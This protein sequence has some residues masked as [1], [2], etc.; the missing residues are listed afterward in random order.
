MTLSTA[1]F[2]ASATATATKS[3]AA[4][5]NAYRLYSP[6]AID[7]YYVAAPIIRDGYNAAQLWI[8]EQA[9]VVEQAIKRAALKSLIAI[10][11]L[12][13]IAF[14]WLQTQIEQ[15]PLYA[16]K[17]QLTGIKAKLFIVRQGIKISSFVSYNGLDSKAQ[18]LAASAKSA[19]IRKG[20]IAR[21]ALDKVFCLG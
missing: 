10:L 2:R 21:T 8:K 1:T 15:A 5:A 4:T 16:L 9:P 6:V 17:L 20:A 3:I 12:A 7:A 11:Q 13:L 14:D 19:W 18:K